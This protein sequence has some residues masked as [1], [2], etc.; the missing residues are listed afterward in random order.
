MTLLAG[1]RFHCTFAGTR[2]QVET[3]QREQRSH[4]LLAQFDG[5]D[6]RYPPGRSRL[7]RGQPLGPVRDPHELG[8]KI[9]LGQGVRGCHLIGTRE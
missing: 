7:R 2:S 8:G 5:Q 9:C 6:A 3:Y 1:Y 4:A